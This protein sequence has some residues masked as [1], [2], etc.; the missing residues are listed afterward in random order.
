MLAKS[1]YL[2][3]LRL[4]AMAAQLASLLA[5]LQALQVGL[6]RSPQVFLVPRLALAAPLQSLR[7]LERAVQLVRV[8]R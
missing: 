7:E 8:A 4:G 3:V 6:L 2:L 5:L 1:V